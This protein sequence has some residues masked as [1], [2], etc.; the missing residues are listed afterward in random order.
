MGSRDRNSEFR[1]CEHQSVSLVRHLQWRPDMTLR[2]KQAGAW[3]SLAGA[4][5]GCGADAPDGE[6]DPGTGHESFSTTPGEPNHEEITATGLSFLRPDIL[7]AL[8]AANVA[9]D[10]EFFFVNANHF[11]DCNFTG[12]SAVV[13]TSQAEAVAQ[14]DPN[15]ALPE[16]DL[17]AIRAFA[18]SLHA[19]QDFYAHTNWIELG[20]DA[21]VDDSLG[22]FP[23]LRPYSSIGP[24]FV[25]VQGRKPKNAALSR[26]DDAAYPASAVV[27]VKLG[28]RRATGLISG[29]VDYEQGNFCPESVAMTHDELNKDKSTNVGRV[30]QYEAAKTLAI[31]QTEHEWCRLRELTRV[32]WGDAGV[33]RL[34]TWVAPGAT[35]PACQ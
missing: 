11:D 22:A 30:E 16:A 12:G 25:V 8:Q 15:A 20:G 6:A 23:S 21:L 5:F 3:V 24:G 33:A 19:L 4:L 27:D 17:L 9:T 28:K 14:L 13:A 2:L 34:D 32:R 1:I 7:L 26:D 31:L 35:A 10:V 18:R 29:T